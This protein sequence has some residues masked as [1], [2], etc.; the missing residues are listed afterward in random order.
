MGMISDVG[1][2]ISKAAY[3]HMTELDDWG[4]I[5]KV[6]EDADKKEER[7]THKLFLWESI[8]WYEC[9]EDVAQLMLALKKTDLENYL[10]IRVGSRMNDI[11]VLGELFEN[12]FGM[13][14]ISSIECD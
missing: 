12:L 7:D 3:E 4:L 14:I 11:E 8:K 5:S 1:L 9:D 10:F 13:R 2:V 6:F